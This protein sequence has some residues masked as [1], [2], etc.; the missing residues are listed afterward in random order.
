MIS[1]LKLFKRDKEQRAIKQAKALR[2]TLLHLGYK[3]C[4]KG[5]AQ[6]IAI[7]EHERGECS[8]QENKSDININFKL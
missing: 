4:P 1:I 5:I 7:W 6:C 8:I 2:K 3:K